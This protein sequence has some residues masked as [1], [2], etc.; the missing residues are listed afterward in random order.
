MAVDTQGDIK[1]VKETYAAS[2]NCL[3]ALMAVDTWA[4]AG[5]A[6]LIVECLNCLSALMA[7]DTCLNSYE[8]GWFPM[9]SIA[10]RL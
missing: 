5:I 2:L 8:S 1:K 6:W 3:S 4:V 7:V 10:F 9:V